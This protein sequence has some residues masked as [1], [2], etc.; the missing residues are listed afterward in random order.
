MCVILKL[1]LSNEGPPADVMYTAIVY[2]LSL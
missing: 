1:F 2:G